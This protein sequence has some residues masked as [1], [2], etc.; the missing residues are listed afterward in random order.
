MNQCKYCKKETQNKYC[1]NLCQQKFQNSKVIELWKKDHTYGVRGGN[2][3]RGPIK[4]H[5]FEKFDHRCSV[6]GWNEKN[7]ITNQSPLEIDHID[8][9]STNNSEDNLRLLCPN[10]HSLTPTWKALN[11]GKGSKS[12]LKQSKLI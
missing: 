8:G 7:P 10:C 4:H 5:I 11:K 9:D 1:S 6:C 12:R 3:L 2:R